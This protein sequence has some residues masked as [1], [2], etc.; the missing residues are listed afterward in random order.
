MLDLHTNFTILNP[1]VVEFFLTTTLL[2]LLVFCIFLINI[3]ETSKIINNNILFPLIFYSLILAILQNYFSSS[4]TITFLNGTLIHDVLTKF[5]HFFIVVSLILYFIL[6]QE[7]AL[8]K[9]Y[10]YFED[11]IIILISVVG[12]LLLCSTYNLILLYLAIELQSLSFYIL[13]GSKRNSPISTEAA[14]KYFILG[15][16]GSGLILYGISIIYGISGSVNLGNIFLLITHINQFEYLAFL[17]SFFYG[18]LFLSTGLLFKLGAAPF[19]AWLPDVYEGSPKHITLFFTT[20]PKITLICLLLRLFLDIGE[21]ISIFFS[22]F[23]YFCSVSSIFIGSLVALQ[24]KKIKRLLAY[25]SISHIG[26]I[27]I[28]FTVCS[29]K[30]I[31]FILFYLVIYIIMSFNIWSIFLAVKLKN[32]PLKYLTS[33]TNFSKINP[34]LSTLIIL[35]LFSLAGIPPLA[36]FFSKVFI[37]FLAIENSFIGLATLAVIISVVSAFYYLR[38]I[39]ILFFDKTKQIEPMQTIQKNE[40]IIIVFTSQLLSFYFI[41][42][43]YILI[44]LEKTVLLFLL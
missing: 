37:L 22:S 30:S 8:N 1:T 35:N 39:K 7:S 27:L 10:N 23:F 29:F 20:L 31:E 13:A 36:G 2:L 19:H 33:C 4:L 43:E 40:S 24:Q 9:N 16:I 44:Y 3:R 18:L 11:N 17:I 26:F 41:F 38:L 28:G 25:S 5:I 14:L 32:K 15:A 12:M 6:Q 21:D 42:P 34:V